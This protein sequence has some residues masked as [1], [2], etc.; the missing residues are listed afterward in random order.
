[1]MVWVE[2]E[3][4]NCFNNLMLGKNMAEAGQGPR[5]TAIGLMEISSQRKKR[6][7]GIEA[8]PR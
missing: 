3:L 7:S 8:L 4:W 1:M 6:W 5:V 2:R